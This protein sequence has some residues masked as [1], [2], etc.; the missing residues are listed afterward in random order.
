MPVFPEQ[1]LHP[2]HA[3]LFRDVKRRHVVVVSQPRIS[4]GAEQFTHRPRVA[5]M[6]REV[7]G[8]ATGLE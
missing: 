3:T 1:V 7:Q 6:A 5:V 4:A 2:P 8:G